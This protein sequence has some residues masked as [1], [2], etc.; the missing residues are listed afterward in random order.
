MLKASILKP[1]TIQYYRQ[2]Y[3]RL[4][5]PDGSA[6]MIESLDTIFHIAYRLFEDSRHIF[7]RGDMIRYEAN[8]LY[9]MSFLKC[10]SVKKLYEGGLSYI[11]PHTQTDMGNFKDPYSIYPIVRAQFEAY[12]IFNNI[13]IQHSGEQ[14]L[15]IY[16]LWVISG[17]KYRQGF[18]S[19][20][21]TPENLRKVA[22]EAAM[23]DEYL[24][25]LQ[26][27][28][29]Y[30]SLSDRNKI[31]I[32]RQIIHRK[33]IQGK[34]TN[35]EIVAQAWHALF[36]SAGTNETFHQLYA[37]LS[38]MTHPSNVSVF[39]FDEI[40]RENGDE[41]M[42]H[43]AVNLSRI[44]TSFFI[45]DFIEAFPVL[46]VAYLGYDTMGQILVDS[47]NRMFRGASYQ[48]SDIA[49]ETLD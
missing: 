47:L 24:V 29:T 5:M 18:A 35:G 43:F 31:Y 28:E 3:N 16:Y 19:V 7:S 38:L 20:A 32:D 33:N 2:E 10:L 8:L 40:F 39:Q 11:N 13:Y 36:S 30:N 34:F 44:I 26:A 23:I 41:N 14:Q 49:S 4:I 45:R 22:D 37:D 48:V 1:M 6:T 12:C 17:L 42:S 15:A 21:T 25:R 46:R 27:L 9:Q